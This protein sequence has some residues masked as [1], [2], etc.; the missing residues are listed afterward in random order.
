M[1]KPLENLTKEEINRRMKAVD[2]SIEFEPD[3]DAINQALDSQVEIWFDSE[4]AAKYG[5]KLPPGATIHLYRSIPDTRW[6][7]FIKQVKWF[8]KR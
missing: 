5:I 6:Q 1:E 3:M 8:F 4:T 7:R 2:P